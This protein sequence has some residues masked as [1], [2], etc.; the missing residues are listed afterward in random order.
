[1]LGRDASTKITVDVP[2]EPLEPGP[3]GERLHVIDYDA[4]N[5][6]YYEPADLDSAWVAMQDGF[7]PSEA[8]PRFHQQMAYAV[9]ARVLENFDVALGWRLDFRKR[10][11][12]RIFP[13]AFDGANA[14]YDRS[15]HALFFGYFRSSLEN[16]GRLL[17][18]QTVF[19]CLSHDVVAHEMTHAMVD[20]LR[21][22]F[23]DA[24]NRD[25]AAFHEGFADIVA[26]FQH[27]SF[28]DVLRDAI[29][30]SRTD[31]RH[32][33]PF[34][35]LATE[36]GHG[37]GM[38]E[39]LRSAIEGPHPA[40]YQTAEEPHERGSILVAAVFA[41]F[42]ATYQRRIAD[43]VRIATG[44]TGLLP[45]GN[46]PPDLV[47]RIAGEAA[48]TAQ[49]TLNMCIR[50][51][52]YL[53]PV[54]ITFGDFL[55]ALVTADHELAPLDEIGLRAAMIE[56]FRARGVY[57]D[58]VISLSEEAL[59]WP[60]PTA[61][62]RLPLD[63]R[64]CGRLFQRLADFSRRR[65]VPSDSSERPP[66]SDAKGRAYRP[67]EPELDV[68]FETWI[69][70][71]LH[72]YAEQNSRALGL[73]AERKIAVGGFHPTVRIGRQGQLLLELVVQFTQ[74]D[75]SEIDARGG[76]PLRAGVTLVA[77]AE[78]NVRY[79]IAKPFPNGGLASAF[80]PLSAIRKQRE[81]DFVEQC[82]RADAFLPWADES[83][84][85]TRIA[86]TTNFRRLHAGRFR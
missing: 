49:A 4:P 39:A 67:D 79:L 36:F 22:Y 74:R 61:L 42:F 47:D 85:K 37:T 1:M 30:N 84:R 31:L 73:D 66:L 50:A 44:G 65:S 71:L 14:F 86:A 51:F 60:T 23:L 20:R 72:D 15:R 64:L 24:T 10:R 70:K 54:D 45:P 68:D 83:Y 48:R 9:A 28:A 17:P 16:A 21:P 25:V 41:G 27:F 81:Q 63:D 5:G 56:A 8:D 59:I 69:A 33:G 52:E 12:L 78:G 3:L 6:R 7:D 2:Y 53:P 46:L 32:A 76:V 35:D 18:G 57:P 19:T 55:R 29:R 40:Q 82:D 62:P 11:P 34:I 26:I 75:V 43:I 77:S 13:H 80:K 58:N 38:G